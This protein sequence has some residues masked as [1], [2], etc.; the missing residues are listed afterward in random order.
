MIKSDYTNSLDPNASE[1]TSAPF[2]NDVPSVSTLETVKR[3]TSVANTTVYAGYNPNDD[4]DAPE[5]GAVGAPIGNFG[6]P[7][8][9]FVVFYIIRTA[10]KRYKRER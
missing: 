6:A 7:L 2:N 10:H 4:I 3:E 5:L 9:L 8:I 1:G